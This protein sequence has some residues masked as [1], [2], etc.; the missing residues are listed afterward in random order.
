MADGKVTAKA[1]AE[2]E[3]NVVEQDV[4]VLHG[5]LAACQYGSRTSRLRVPKCHGTYM[6]DMPLMTYKDTKVNDNVQPFGFC[7]CPDNPERQ[8]IAQDIMKKVEDQSHDI[9]DSIMDFFAGEPEKESDEY[10]DVLMEN[11][12]V[13]C[14]PEAFSYVWNDASDDLYINEEKALITKC[15]CLCRQCGA[16]IF[17]VDDGQNNAAF[18]QQSKTDLSDWK[19]GDPIPDASE[20]NLKQLEDLGQ[21]D[22]ELYKNMKEQI[23]KRNALD[24]EIRF[25]DPENEEERT[26]LE[27]QRE[28]L[29][30]AY[31]SGKK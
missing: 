29:E 10:S 5:G 26:K 13:P 7:Q 19:E 6:H 14:H 28:D 3:E 16:R 20:T 18:E 12:I 27:K 11:I 17:I 1:E 9:L 31:K 30:N 23:E 21:T 24:N 8:L 25:C 4:Y 15:T 2:I 22:S